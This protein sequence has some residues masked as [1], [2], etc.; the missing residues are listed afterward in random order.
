MVKGNVYTKAEVRSLQLAYRQAGAV[1]AG[2][3][4]YPEDIGKWKTT[5]AKKTIAVDGKIGCYL[6]LIFYCSN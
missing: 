2:L 4:T 1:A 3:C 6:K 5:T